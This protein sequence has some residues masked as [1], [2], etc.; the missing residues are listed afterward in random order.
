MWFKWHAT[1]LRKAFRVALKTHSLPCLPFWPNCL[2][3]PG[4]WC[5]GALWPLAVSLR[6]LSLLLPLPGVPATG[7]SCPTLQTSAFKTQAGLDENVHPRVCRWNIPFQAP[8]TCWGIHD[9]LYLL[10]LFY[11]FIFTQNANFSKTGSMIFCLCTPGAWFIQC[12]MTCFLKKTCKMSTGLPSKGK[13]PTIEFRVSDTWVRKLSSG[14]WP[15]LHPCF[16][17]WNHQIGSYLHV[18]PCNSPAF[19]L[20]S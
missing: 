12:K 15:S 16:H 20:Q 3:Q 4:W 10:F 1:C 17:T 8:T 11:V 9:Y 5:H 2:L 18:S 7:P 6:P 14:R 13:C 19:L